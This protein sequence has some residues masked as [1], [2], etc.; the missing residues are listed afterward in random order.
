M[1]IAVFSSKNYDR[2]FLDAAAERTD[3]RHQFT[4]LD[5]RLDKQ[6]ALL[7][8]GHD[9]A[10]AFVNDRLDRQVLGIL[11]GEGVR[12]IALRS[13]GFNH[14]DLEAARKEGLTV[15][16]VPAYSPD[17]VAEHTA[18]L[19]LSLNRKIHKAYARVREG[20]FALE[21]LLGFDLRG[22]TVGIVGTGKI[23]LCMAGIMK[24][25]GC[26]LIAHDPKPDPQMENLGGRYVDLDELF[27]R[28]DIISLHCPLTPQTYHLIDHQAIGKM[29]DGI[30]LINT[31]RGGVV[32][33]RALIAGLKS[34]SIGSVGLDVYEEEGDLF[35]ENLSSKMIQDDVFARLLTFP[36][37]LITGH[38]AF[39]TREAMTAIAETT[40]ANIT[41]FEENGVALHEVSVEK[42]A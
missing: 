21:G 16:R 35:F 42:L 9:A 8:K 15:A 27:E 13:A 19:I 12:L 39:F 28:S 22:R 4:Y 1:R 6:S 20:N 38:Q 18:A 10:C 2:T 40:I 26:E 37:V 24:G 3:G 36:N 30:M 34:G 33:A 14:V 23:G 11:A 17:A 31:S 41:S 25:F 7:A 5:G 32:D 29:K